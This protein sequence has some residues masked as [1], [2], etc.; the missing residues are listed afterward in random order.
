MHRLQCQRKLGWDQVIS[1]EQQQEWKNICKQAN[2]SSL[3][4]ISRYAGPREGNF[5]LVAFT[6]ASQVLYGTVIFIQHIKSGKLNFIQAKNRMVNTQLKTK[7]IPSLEMNAISLGV[8]TL[9]EIQRSS[10]SL[11]H[12]TNQYHRNGTFYRFSLFTSMTHCIVL[13]NG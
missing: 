2:K 11:V 13:Q 1:L 6:D 5:R 8:E 7:S 9:M 3:V 10:R 12:E 4:K